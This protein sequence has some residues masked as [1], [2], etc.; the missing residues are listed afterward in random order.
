MRDCLK[1]QNNELGNRDMARDSSKDSQRRSCGIGEWYGTL[2][3]ELSGSQRREF[4]EIALGADG[5][6]PS[7]RCPFRAPR[8]DGGECTKNGGVCSLRYYSAAADEADGAVVADPVAELCTTCPYRFDEDDIVVRWVGETVLGAPRPFSVAELPFLERTGGGPDATAGP[9]H[10]GRIDRVLVHPNTDQL[11]WCAL[12]MQAVY[13]SGDSMKKE[14]EFLS[15][16]A[17]RED[18]LPRGRR[19]PDFRSS[20]PK[21]LMPQLQIKVPTLRRWGKKMCVVVDRQFFNA[22]APME[23]QT[24]LSNCDIVW[25]VVT[26]E[27]VGNVAR[28]TPG[29]VRFTTLERAVEGLTAGIPVTLPEFEKRLRRKLR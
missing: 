29:D 22:M 1:P 10:V 7:I 21:R 27:Q 23:E 16:P 11:Q 9:K 6:P 4:A 19:R 15:G 2:F 25:F 14:F 8:D 26:Y 20:G 18:S 3:S 24:D 12:E 5:A 28:L 13:F 17:A